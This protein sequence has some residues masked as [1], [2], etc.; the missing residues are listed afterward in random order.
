MDFSSTIRTFAYDPR[1]MTFRMLKSARE[2]RDSV[3]GS[4]PCGREG[5]RERG[6]GGERERGR[7]ERKREE[8]EHT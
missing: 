3:M 1:P 2:I 4:V 8:R 6:G 7:G 5:E